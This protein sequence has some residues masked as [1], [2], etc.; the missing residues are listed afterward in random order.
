MNTTKIFLFTTLFVCIILCIVNLFKMQEIKDI[1]KDKVVE[2]E[3]ALITFELNFEENQC[4]VDSLQ[5][6][7]DS[8][9]NRYQIF[10]KSPGKDMVD[11]LNAIIQVESRGNPNAYAPGEDA[12][13]IL[14]I[15]KCMVDDVNR[16][17]K[18][19][20][21]FLRY[22]YNDRW[23]EDKSIEMFDIFCTYYGL[24]TAEEMARCWNGGPR[25]INNPYTLKYWNKVELEL[26]EGY[27]SR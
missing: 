23:D 16:I 2:Y 17:L 1:Y 7:L 27:A 11:I 13:G 24:T 20:G 4:I 9:S 8:L 6:A 3:E 10:D 14:Q 18:K 12:V 15:R 21:A 19:R 25:G 5:N 22:T 26:E